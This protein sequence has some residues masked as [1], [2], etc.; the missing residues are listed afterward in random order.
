[1]RINAGIEKALAGRWIAGYY[2]EDALEKARLL[3]SKGL[4]AII[5]FLGEE[6]TKKSEINEAVRTYLQL[7]KEIKKRKLH[8]SISLKPTQIG[9]SINYGLMLSNYLKIAKLANQNHI[10]VWLDMETPENIN[11]TI[12]VYERSVKYGNTGICIQAYLKRS[13]DDVGKLLKH[14]AKIRL[15]KGAYQI[16]SDEVF[17]SKREINHNYLNITRRL[18]KESD[19]FML[20]THDAR[21]IEEAVRLNKRYNKKVTYAMLNGI[22]SKYAKYLAK[23]GHRVAVYV[24]FGKDWLSFGYRRLVEQRHISLILRSLLE[25]QEI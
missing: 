19:D 3:N 24:P 16:K 13:N 17:R 12:R 10:F 8:A 9:L 4:Y 21:I 14:K 23:H 20:A 2:A 15:V 25:K 5:N 7:I 6:K 22:R 1:M 11:N 18:F